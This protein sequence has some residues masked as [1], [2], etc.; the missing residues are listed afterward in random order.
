LANAGGRFERCRD[1]GNHNA[2]FVLP[3]LFENRTLS[4]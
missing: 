4:F 1:A 2:P 3:F